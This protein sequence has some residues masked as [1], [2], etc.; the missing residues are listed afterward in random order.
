MDKEKAKFVLQSFRPDGADASDPD[1]AEALK[2]AVTDRELGEWLLQERAFDADFSKAIHSVKLP[3]NLRQQI[4]V[5]L[6]S[7]RGGYPQAEDAVDAQLIGA[8]ASIQPPAWLREQAIVAME[9]TVVSGEGKAKKSFLR[10]VWFPVTAAAAVLALS[11]VGLQLGRERAIANAP[12]IKPSALSSGFAVAHDSIFFRLDKKSENHGELIHYAKKQ[13]LPFAE[14]LPRGLQ[15]LKSLGCR[16][17]VI[18]GKR[19]SLFCFET[20]DRGTIHLVIFRRDDVQGEVPAISQ[21]HFSQEGK[22][23][24]A[25]WADEQNVYLIANNQTQD[26]THLF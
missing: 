6:T 2:L 26:L 22:W 1:F 17:M 24:S 15:A 18:G 21:P 11:F 14:A 23:A 20:S 19:G 7:E 13:S 16:E 10:R 25:S 4:L 8:F 9:R 5:G 3:E 12:D